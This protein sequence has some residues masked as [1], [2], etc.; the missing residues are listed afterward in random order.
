[1][2]TRSFADGFVHVLF[3]GLHQYRDLG[4]RLLI[5]LG[6]CSFE[7]HFGSILTEGSVK[8]YV[9]G[10]TTCVEAFF[11]VTCVREYA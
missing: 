1:M 5:L 10:A 7:D 11:E 2:N 6:E 8:V 4:N 3:A 9:L